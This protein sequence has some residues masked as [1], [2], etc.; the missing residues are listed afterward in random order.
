MILLIVRTVVIYAMVIVAMRLM[1][2]RQLGELQPGELVTTFLI[3]NVASICIEEPELPIAA[4]L[5]PIFLITAMEIL[6]SSAAWCCP[7]YARLLFGKQ[8]TV[9]RDGE[10]D[11]RALAELRITTGDLLEALRGKDVLS[12]SDVAW[13]VIETNG[14]LNLAQK[15]GQG[16]AP[17]VYPLLVDRFL[18]R[19]TL[20][21]F[22]K[23]EA[24]LH[25]EL[26]SRGLTEKDVL[27]LLYDGS[28]VTLIRRERSAGGAK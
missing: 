8:I 19:E 25:A 23:D 22:G 21:Y 5:V 3:S 6:N 2:K 7:A 28:E 27:A 20:R 15:P 26:Q 1:G 17:P 13:G 9:I 10:L 14:T 16:E 24:W 12:P 4:S 11:Q 18:Y